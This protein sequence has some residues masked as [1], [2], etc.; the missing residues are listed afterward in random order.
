MKKNEIEVGGRYLARVSG[1][2]VT[3]RVDSFGESLGKMVYDVTNLST[4]RKLRFDPAKEEFVGD[5]L[6]NRYA[7]PPMRA[8]WHL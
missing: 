3:V 4:G 2:L 8:P 5:E 6:A 7:N 1:R